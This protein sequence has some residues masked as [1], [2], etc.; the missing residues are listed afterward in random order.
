MAY[1]APASAISAVAPQ[2]LTLR[3]VGERY[4]SWFTSPASAGVCSVSQSAISLRVSLDLSELG[5]RSI[6]WG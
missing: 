3:L 5:R 4:A 1:V 6:G 2:E